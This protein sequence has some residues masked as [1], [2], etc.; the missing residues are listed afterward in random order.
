MKRATQ[1]AAT[2]LPWSVP[3]VFAV[4]SSQF[5]LAA[6]LDPRSIGSH[7]AIYT[8]AA[9]AWISGLDPWSIG[10]TSAVFAGPPPMLIPFV[11]FVGLPVELTRVFFASSALVLAVLVI[12]RLRLPGWWIGF[13][14]IFQAIYMGHPEM[15]LLA[16][17]V[18]GGPV[19]GLAALVK[20]YFAGPLIAERRWRAIA[21]A[22]IPLAVSV[23]IL[24]WTSFLK[25]LP[26]IVETL[27]RQSVGDSTFGVPLLM[28]VA[29]V[30]LIALGPRRALWLAAPALWPAAQ[31]VYKVACLPA[32]S[33]LL[34]LLWAIPIPGMTLAGLVTYAVADR[35]LTQ[36]RHRAWLATPL[37]NSVSSPTP[38]DPV[39]GNANGRFRAT[40]PAWTS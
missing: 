21:I 10:P 24:P 7:A 3:V 23:L 32:M 19:A 5:L 4:A 18:F 16:L 26:A 35:I 39:H 25:Q 8:A 22:L 30:A 12:R 20:P 1:L 27:Q 31:P 40:I 34:G 37:D 17:L 14:P 13:P 36:R 38:Q 6:V 15:L 33:P 2:A 28:A 11:P 9:S 29:V